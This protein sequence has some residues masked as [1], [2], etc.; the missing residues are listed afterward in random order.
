MILA[1]MPRVPGILRPALHLVFSVA[2]FLALGRERR[3]A[4]RNLARATGRRGA[5]LHLL[6][7]RLFYNFSHFLVAYTQMPPHARTGPGNRPEGPG[8]VVLGEEEAKRKLSAAL[9]AGR[10]LILAGMHLGQWDLALALLARMGIPVT[11]VMRKEDED[12]ARHAAAARSAA[13]VRVVHARESAWLGVELMA[14]LR[15]NE[16][17]A[18]QADRA[19]GD[20]TARVAFFGAGTSIPSGPWDLAR[21]SGA[22]IMTAVA[23]L[24]GGRRCRLVCGDAVF[25][26]GDGPA[27]PM[28]DRAAPGRGSGSV[29]PGAAATSVGRGRGI[30]RLVAAMESLIAAHPDHWFNFY[31]VWP[32]DGRARGEAVASK[33][34]ESPGA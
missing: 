2:F 23:L 27:G 18:L 17:V 29:R 22:P 34:V 16:I 30:E 13:G 21:A 5:A 20:R 25:A 10:G 26:T 8:F 12:A 4:R 33:I 14:A 3:A 7:L 1:I 32:T 19:Y 6:T 15:R 24:E 11:V 31:D 9:D 28:E